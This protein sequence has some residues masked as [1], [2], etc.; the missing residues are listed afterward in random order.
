VPSTV[1]EDS[2]PLAGV[3]NAGVV[4][5]GDVKVL[6]VRVSA[7]AKVANVPV[8]G[9]DTFVAPKR[10]SVVAKLPEI[11]SVLAALFAMPVPPRAGDTWL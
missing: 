10:V 11:A 4:S 5:V 1:H 9:S 7:P 2:V 8:V 6:L 3:P